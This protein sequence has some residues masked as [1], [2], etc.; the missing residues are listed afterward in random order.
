MLSGRYCEVGL[1]PPC[2]TSM[3]IVSGEGQKAGN[4]AIAAN[5]HHGPHGLAGLGGHFRMRKAAQQATGVQGPDYISPTARFH[6]CPTRPVFEPQ[7]TYAPL[8]LIEP[9]GD[10]P[11]HH[12]L[13]AGSR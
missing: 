2:P 11:L 1:H 8:E 4:S 5:R 13:A 3:T 6:P 12:S 9:A 10:S 7:L